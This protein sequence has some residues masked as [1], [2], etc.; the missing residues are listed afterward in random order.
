LIQDFNNSESSVNHISVRP[1]LMADRSMI[2]LR[3]M[4]AVSEIRMRTQ[5]AY[6]QQGRHALH[7]FKFET[8]VLLTQHALF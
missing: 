1:L 2:A 8:N 6:L 4:R 5:A 3:V 7:R